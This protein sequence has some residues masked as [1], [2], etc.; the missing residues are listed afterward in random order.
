MAAKMRELRGEWR[1]REREGRRKQVAQ[2]AA[3]RGAMLERMSEE[4]RADFWR[5]ERAEKERLEQLKKAEEEINEDESEEEL[6]EDE[7]EEELD[8]DEEE[9]NEGEEE[10]EY[11]GEEF[12]EYEDK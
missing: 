10:E 1:R 11:E 8:E 5:A 9:L 2:R 7:S 4:E 12:E 6:D 3:E